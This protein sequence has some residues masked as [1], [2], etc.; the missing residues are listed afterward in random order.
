MSMKL[1]EESCFSFV[2]TSTSRKIREQ[3]ICSVRGLFFWLIVLCVLGQKQRFAR[4]RLHLDGKKRRLGV[5]R[6]QVC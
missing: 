3:A 5:Q 4:A 1:N 6:Q 2:D